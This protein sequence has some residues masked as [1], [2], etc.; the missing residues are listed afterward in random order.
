MTLHDTIRSRDVDLK[1]DGFLPQPGP[2]S[3]GV[4]V[5]FS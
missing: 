1:Y 4:R 2:E 5:I 3:R